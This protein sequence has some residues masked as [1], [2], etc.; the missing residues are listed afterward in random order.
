VNQEKIEPIITKAFPLY[1]KYVHGI[2]FDQGR[3]NALFKD[4][5]PIGITVHY[6]ADRRVDRV[7]RA[8]KDRNLN[9]HII[10]DDNGHA[11]Q[12]CD[13]KHGVSHAG[14]AEWMGHSPNRS[15]ISVAVT[16]WG[17]LKPTENG[18]E[19]WTGAIIPKDEVRTSPGNIPGFLYWDKI[20]PDQE[21][22]LWRFLHWAVGHGIDPGHICGHDECATPKGRKNDP[23]GVLRNTMEEIRTQLKATVIS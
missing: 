17:W 13:F 5:R 9:Y 18:F 1:Y 2:R 15:H 7:M 8:L 16:S 4:L 6:T 20:N 23:G 3:M 12:T 19:A 22:A 11:I 14:R 10:I 21:L